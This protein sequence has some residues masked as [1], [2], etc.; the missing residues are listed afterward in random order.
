MTLIAA[1]ILLIAYLFFLKPGLA[2]RPASSL[3]HRKKP[4]P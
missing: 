2:R 3:R 1:G 4:S